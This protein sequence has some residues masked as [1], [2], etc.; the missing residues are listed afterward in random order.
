MNEN[1]Q[2]VISK[3]LHKNLKSYCSLNEQKIKEYAEAALE[4]AI[5][6]QMTVEELKEK[7]YQDSYA[8]TNRGDPMIRYGKKENIV[9]ENPVEENIIEKEDELEDDIPDIE[10]Q[11]KNVKEKENYDIW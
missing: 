8:S 3:N 10:Q 9:E 1:K 7:Q 6:N 5:E 4:Y 2:I 11:L